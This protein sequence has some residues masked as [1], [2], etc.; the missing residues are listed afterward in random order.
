VALKEFK[1]LKSLNHPGVI[2]MHDAF[3]HNGKETI[4]LVMDFVEGSAL[5][6]FVDKYLTDNPSK[7]NLSGGLPIEM[8]KSIIN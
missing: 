1:L 7:K 3:V 8:C 4:Y 2:K 5:N 6:I